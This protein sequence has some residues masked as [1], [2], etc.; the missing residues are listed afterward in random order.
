MAPVRHWKSQTQKN[1]ETEHL[2]P[3]AKA[4]DPKASP[5]RYLARKR[6]EL[7]DHL[8]LAHPLFMRT[9]DETGGLLMHS[10]TSRHRSKTEQTAG[11][12]DRVSK[13]SLCNRWAF[14]RG[15]QPGQTEEERRTAHR[16]P[17][18]K[19]TCFHAN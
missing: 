10:N 3:S 14:P 13:D 17:R 9:D 12:L 18:P 8:S 6:L 5:A 7:L 1:Q 4:G 15:H 16:R 11:A 2:V 19:T